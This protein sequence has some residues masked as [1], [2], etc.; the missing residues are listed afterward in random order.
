MSS[1]IKK[2]VELEVNKFLNVKIK[3]RKYLVCN[4]KQKH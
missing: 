4:R 1:R 2:K 3:V